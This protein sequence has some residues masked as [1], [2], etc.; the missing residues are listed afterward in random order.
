MPAISESFLERPTFSHF[1]DRVGEKGIREESF[2]GGSEIKSLRTENAQLRSAIEELCRAKIERI[3][4]VGT[5]VAARQD[6]LKQKVQDVNEWIKLNKNTISCLAGAGAG[7]VILTGGT[8]AVVG[9]IQV[10]LL[11]GGVAI[12]GGIAAGI[13]TKKMLS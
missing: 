2:S 10:P 6:S 3:L 7:A 11:L 13:L 12:I 4:D 1:S 8:I 5:R 9:S